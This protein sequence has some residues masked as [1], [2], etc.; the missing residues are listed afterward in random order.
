[1]NAITRIGMAFVVMTGCI[2]SSTPGSEVPTGP[3][4]TGTLYANRFSV[5]EAGACKLLQV[6]DPWQNS[7]GMTFS[8][9]LGSDIDAVPDSLSA[10]PFIRVPVTRVI[11][12]STTHVAMISQLGKA[13]T[14]LGASGTGYIL[15]SVVSHRIDAGKVKEVGYEQGLNYEVIVEINPDVM[16]VYGVEGSIRPVSEKLGELGIQVVYCA[17]YLEN[18]PLGKA[19]WIRFFAHFYNME[20]ESLS[21]FTRIDSAY[22]ALADLSGRLEDKPKVIIGL[23]WK[24][25]WYVAGGQSFASRL[26][27]DAG[28]DYLWREDP[29]SEAIPIDLESVFSRAVEADVWI[30]PGT[31]QSIRELVS[32]DE[33]FLELPVVGQG[34]IYN[35]N[36]RMSRGGGNDYWESGSVRPDL[37]LA[38]LISVFHPDLLADHSLFYY[39]KLK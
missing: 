27:R 10:I 6:F 33:R 8:Y 39:R 9:V 13:E 17:E 38:D 4:N 16:F 30:N 11:T 19:E 14:I 7:R 29:S 32:F 35:N 34:E 12:M 21:F 25:T 1:M 31:A 2:R 28:G 37:I 23:P 15:D 20:E 24:D 22:R 3:A 26:I 18:H 36:A 5:K